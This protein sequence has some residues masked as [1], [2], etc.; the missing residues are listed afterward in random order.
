MEKDIQKPLILGNYFHGDGEMAWAWWVEEHATL[1]IV[2][3]KHISPRKKVVG[4]IT[5]LMCRRDPNSVFTITSDSPQEGEQVM[6]NSIPWVEEYPDPPEFFDDRQIF[7]ENRSFFSASYFN[8]IAKIKDVPRNQLLPPVS[9]K[10]HLEGPLL[11]Y[12]RAIFGLSDDSVHKQDLLTYLYELAEVPWIM[13]KEEGRKFFI[14]PSQSLYEQALSFLRAVWTFWAYTCQTE[15]PQQMLLVLEVPKEL[16]RAGVDPMIEKTV[17]QA[18]RIL[19][20]V[21]AVTTTSIILS[22]E[23]LYPAP[24]L[25]FRYKLLFQTADAD[26][27]FTNEG[28][29][30]MVAPEMLQ[31][32]E[33]GNQNVGL[34]M[35]D[36]AVDESDR[37]ILVRIGEKSPFFWDDFVMA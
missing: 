1:A 32:W 21:S 29:R 35:D 6:V 14:D 28:V 18:M 36:Y 26:L 4:E 20:Y 15:E 37:Q 25:S 33:R 10:P 12:K 23:M 17:F 5:E 7:I 2:G 30:N 3:D 34:W 19:K 31:E 8:L 13:V 22:S 9:F 11:G 24:E 16:L 27:D